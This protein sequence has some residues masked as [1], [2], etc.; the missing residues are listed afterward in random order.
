MEHAEFACHSSFPFMCQKC[1]LQSGIVRDGGL[2][3]SLERKIA[4][5][6]DTPS[7]WI[8]TFLLVWSGGTRGSHKSDLLQI[9][10]V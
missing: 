9:E 1:V 2:V 8:N 6:G 4:S 3:M 7:E 10:Q 5:L